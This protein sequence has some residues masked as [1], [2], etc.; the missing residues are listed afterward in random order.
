MTIT[1]LTNEKAVNFNPPSFTVDNII[2]DI[3]EPFPNQASFMVFCGKSR[4]G[5]TSL[6]IN[7]IT[8]KRMYRGKFDNILV[9][10]P[11][12]SLAS[13]K[14]N[15]FESL[16][17]DKI[18]HEMDYETLDHIHDKIEDYASEGEN[19]LLII[20]DMTAHLKNRDVQKLLSMM[21]NNRRHLRL[22]IWMLVQTYR[23]IPLHIRKTI[24]YLIMYSPSNKKETSSIWE[25]LLTISKD[26]FDEIISYV[27]QK[28]YEYLVI[29]TDAH[30]F[31]K[32]FNELKI[33]R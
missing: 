23:S 25:E 11:Q 6:M 20:D 14:N 27:F 2:G 16:D 30:V 4:S 13:M 28:K 24:N 3:P 9:I 26:E 7:L 18:K 8:S 32:K 29:D 31:F 21:I 12:H 1:E 5:K 33:S 22:S 15:I 17:D 10:S 19:N